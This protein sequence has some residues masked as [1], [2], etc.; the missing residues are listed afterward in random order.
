MSLKGLFQKDLQFI[1]FGGKGGVGKTTMAAASAITFARRFPKKKT[2][3]FTTDPAPSLG[4]S[5]DQ[6]LSKDPQKIRDRYVVLSET[7]GRFFGSYA[8]PAGAKKRLHQIEFFKHLRHKKR[9]RK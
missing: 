1:L 6:K 2:L 7:T 4:D 9:A 5:F 8:T 3:I